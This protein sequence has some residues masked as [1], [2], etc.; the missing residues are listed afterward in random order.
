M[1]SVRQ[2][3]LRL[4]QTGCL[5]GI[6][7][8][9][10]SVHCPISDET[11]R[12]AAEAQLKSFSQA[13]EVYR[14]DMGSYPA[15]DLGLDALVQRGAQGSGWKGPYLKADAIPLDP[16]G[17]VYLYGVDTATGRYWMK[18]QERR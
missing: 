3:S 8:M 9:A 7:S 14:N 2:W 4:L 15:S 1:S 16:W 5:V 17:H 6:T 18:Y 12:M 10:V 11:R 13:L